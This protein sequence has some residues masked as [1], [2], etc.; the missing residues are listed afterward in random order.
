MERHA[1]KTFPLNCKDCEKYNLL[2]VDLC[3]LSI[4]VVRNILY[5]PLIQMLAKNINFTNSFN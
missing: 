3:Q 5:S 4:L 1:T 2:K